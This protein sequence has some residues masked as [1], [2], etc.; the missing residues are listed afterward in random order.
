M[1]AH[2]HS[3]RVAPEDEHLGMEHIICTGCTSDYWQDRADTGS[4]FPEEEA[5][6]EEHSAWEDRRSLYR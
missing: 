3:Y 2:A 6:P 1:S 4:P 5:T